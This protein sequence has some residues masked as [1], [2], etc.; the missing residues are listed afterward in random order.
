MLEVGD[1]AYDTST[2]ETVRIIEHAVLWGIHSYRVLNPA[3]GE[4]YRASEEVL[5]PVANTVTYDEDYLRFVMELARI[6]N[7]VAEGVLTP[8]S[9]NLIPLPHQLHALNRA[10]ANNNVRYLLA[11]E[12]GLGKTI[13]AG[14]ILEELKTRGLVRRTLVVCP[15]GLATQWVAEM[16]EKFGEKF[17]LLLPSD[18][19]AIRKVTEGDNVYREFE[20]VVTPMDSIKPLEQR[21]G[22]SE[23][24]IQKYNDD[25]INAVVNGNWDL[26]IIDEA[27]RVAGSTGDVA[28]HK[29]GRL[30][31]K[32][33]PYLLLLTATPH[34]GKSEPFLR[35]VR[36][37]DRDAFPN[38]KSVVRS[39]VAPY[40]I[41][42]EKRE[43]I[44]NKGDLLFKNRATHLVRIGWDA[45]HTLQEELYRRVSDYV[46]HTYNQAMRQKSRNMCLIFLLIIMQRMVTS[47]TAAVRQSLE[48][49]LAMLEGG[50][51]QQRHMNETDIGET[52]IEDGDEAAFEAPSLNDRSEIAELQDLV[53]LAQ[54]AELQYQDAKVEALFD[55]LDAV[56]D[57]GSRKVIIFTE[58]MATQDYLKRL[59][60][61]RGFTVSILNGSMSI[62]ERN[63][64]TEEFR[65]KT[66]VFVST[67][68]GGEGLNLQF[69]SVVI[70]YDMPWN[71]MR[72]EQRCGRVDRIG[73]TRDVE[74]YNFM[75]D[76]TVESR[77]HEVIE[78]KLSVILD[79]LGIDKYSDVL[80]SE[81][82][83][84]DFTNAY[85]GSIGR[86][87][88][89]E[90]SAGR[91]EKEL[92]EQVS[93]VASYQEIIREDKDLGG[94]VGLESDFDVTAALGR[95]FAYYN[96]WRGGKA[97]LPLGLALDSPDAEKLLHASVVQDRNADVLSVEIEDFP[98]E[99]GWFMLWDLSIADD[100]RSTRVVP[101]F[102]ND[103]LVLRPIAG[104]R[105]MDALLRPGVRLVVGTAA[106]VD[107]ETWARLEELSQDFAY[108]DFKELSEKHEAATRENHDKYAYALEL[109]HEAA[110]RM[111]IENIRVAKLARIEAE[112]A[113]M[114]A[115]YAKERQVLPEFR[116][117]LLVRLVES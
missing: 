41:R 36:L 44:D 75:I 77:V 105:I 60:E 48:R 2:Q 84:L 85:M 90:K 45:R 17:H 99:N 78:E 55:T 56:L 29:L 43:A 86:P 113:E 89:V 73:Q 96:A 34:N 46:S 88:A 82:C 27:H 20:Q 115:A 102:V 15:T 33:S 68:A 8:L 53:N 21:F 52:D 32:A 42:T 61:R 57:E 71:P 47:S 51:T 22:W 35:L 18:F 23:E 58:F 14:L 72:I 66:D 76:D 7:E 94:L 4:T 97:T 12:V 117:M 54:R 50:G 107:A 26:V 37:L 49:R 16:Q 64:V 74:V 19:D 83:D 111:G 3:T 93:N 92:R 95:A 25:R 79:E 13:E 9:R 98:N 106:N 38:E 87:Q 112:R 59:L 67:D 10:L 69:A 5:R 101:V 63:A 24:R 30:L 31:A 11:D 109:R 62:D 28:R 103:R 110:R 114:E 116:C 65:T 91:I 6:K 39:Q 108:N 104:K 81:A 80:D 100:R 70:N 1:L 40:L